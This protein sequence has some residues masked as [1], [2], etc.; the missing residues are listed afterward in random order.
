MLQLDPLE[1]AIDEPIMG[2]TRHPYFTLPEIRIL[3]SY[4]LSGS[5]VN[6]DI[7]SSEIYLPYCDTSCI[8]DNRQLLKIRHSCAVS[9]I[10]K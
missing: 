10:S 9:M 7:W 8:A 6:F 5:D 3:R 1:A 4:V 2:P